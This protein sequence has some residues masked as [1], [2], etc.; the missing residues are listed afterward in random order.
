M[1]VCDAGTPLITIIYGN[2][3]VSLLKQL[4]PYDIFIL[5]LLIFPSY[6]THKTDK[7]NLYIFNDM[8]F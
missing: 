4:Y 8:I 6:K 1:G 7:S 5:I 2:V 3:G